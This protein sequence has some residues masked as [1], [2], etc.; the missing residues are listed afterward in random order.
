MKPSRASTPLQF[1]RRAVWLLYSLVWLL[2]YAIWIFC[3]VVVGF[4]TAYILV[5]AIATTALLMISPLI[6]WGW[7]YGHL[8]YWLIKYKISSALS[9]DILQAQNWVDTSPRIILFVPIYF[10]IFQSEVS[11]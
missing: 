6:L 1:L 2:G 8:I 5:I 7:T 10:Y 9:W 3:R 11:T 4:F